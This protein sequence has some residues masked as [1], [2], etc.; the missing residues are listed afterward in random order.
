MSIRPG[1]LGV[2]IATE[3]RAELGRQNRSRRWLAEQLG[4]PHN[5]LSRWVGGE[6]CPPL[7]ELDRMCTAL[8]LNVVEVMG[9]AKYRIEVERGN[10]PTIP[11]QQTGGFGR[12]ASDFLAFVAA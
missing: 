9:A 11:T 10:M 8:G 12:R 1:P 2:R 6:T 4:V 3:L 7:D 5:T